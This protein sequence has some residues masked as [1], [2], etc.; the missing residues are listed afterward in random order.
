MVVTGVQTAE[1]QKLSAATQGQRPPDANPET[2]KLV[3]PIRI[4]DNLYYVGTDYVS[5]YVVKT[6]AGLIMIDS[7]Y[8][9]FTAQAL[10]AMERAGLDPKTIK[11]VLV[12]HGHNDHFGG[13]RAI[14]D[15]SGA[16]VAM[17]EADWAM[18]VRPSG[19]NP[20]ALRQDIVIRDGD[21]IT[22]GDTSFK[23]YITPGHTTGVA[24]MEFE[25]LDGTRKH[26][27]FMFGG[28]NVTSNRAQDFEMFIGSVKRLM[29]TLSNVDVSLTSHPWGALIF[30]RAALLAARKPGDPHPFVDPE[31]FRAFLQERLTD[32]QMRLAAATP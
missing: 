31:D 9:E 24:S 11:Y 8:N 32:A 22:L 28:H 5:A 26:K 21:S 27:A 7:L 17:T 25:V 23:F 16:R 18:A 2:Q 12:T 29:S 3:P 10:Q 4:F 30:Q 13:A 6:S 20:P 14:Q 15:L 1:A 19:G